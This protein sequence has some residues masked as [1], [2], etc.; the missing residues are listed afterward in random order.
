M[1]APTRIP[2]LLLM[3]GASLPQTPKQKGAFIVS[4]AVFRFPFKGGNAYLGSKSMIRQDS[5]LAAVTAG[6]EMEFQPGWSILCEYN[7][8]YVG[9][10]TFNLAGQSKRVN[11]YSAALRYRF[12]SPEAGGFALLGITNALGSTTGFSLSPGLN[13][14]NAIFLGVSITR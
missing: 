11:T 6:A 13:N 8:I 10:N 9:K 7:A 1:Y 5:D 14:S 4:G 3:A 12:G 2:G